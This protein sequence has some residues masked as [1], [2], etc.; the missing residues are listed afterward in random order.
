MKKLLTLKMIQL[1]VLSLFVLVLAVGCS[2]NEPAPGTDVGTSNNVEYGLTLSGVLAGGDYISFSSDDDISTFFKGKVSGNDYYYRGF[3]GGSVMIDEEMDMGMAVKSSAQS[4]NA[5]PVAPGGMATGEDGGLDYSDTNV[6]VEGIDEADIIKTDG[7]FIYVTSGNHFF[8]VKAYPGEEAQV[9][10]SYELSQ[11]P[12]GLFVSGDKV[13]IVDSSYGMKHFDIRASQY[14]TTSRVTVLDVSDRETPTQITNYSIEGDY[15]TARM[16][17]DDIYVVTTYGPQDWQVPL[18]IIMREETA[19][20]IAPSNVFRMPIMYKNPQL[21]S[22]HALSVSDPTQMDTISVAVEGHPTVYMSHEN[23]FLTSTKY[24]SEYDIR[25]EI[26]KE[27]VELPS[28]EQNLVSRINNVDD[29]ILTVNEKEGKVIQVY[30]EYIS[31]LDDSDE[32]YDK[33]TDATKKKLESLESSQITTVQRIALRTN[34]ASEDFSPQAATQLPGTLVNQFS[35]DEYDSIFRVAVTIQ[36]F[37]TQDRRNNEPSNAIYTFD[38]SLEVVDSLKGIAETERIF[39][40]RFMGDRLYM[41]TFRQTDPFFVYDLEDGKVTQL[42]ELKIP[43]FSRYLHPYDED[44]LIGLG[45]DAT[46]TGRQLGIKISL[47]DVSDVSNPTEVTSFVTEEKYAQTNAEYEHKAFLFDREKE[48]LVIPAR[49]YDWRNDGEGY[50][51]AFV[52]DISRV[53]IELRG[54]I[55]HSRGQNQYYGSGVLRSLYIEDDLYTMSEGLI[56]VNDLGD[57]HSVA[58]VSLTATGSGPIKVY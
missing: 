6:Q 38:Q 20:D 7:E 55:D 53:S 21:A 17:G 52:F 36:P 16:K 49:S 26:M 35:M 9:L 33:I 3:N 28:R 4:P 18:P 37:W 42:G 12:Q 41:V 40:T 57:L 8:I 34:S 1:I 23:I 10:S 54:L 27:L 15:V 56:R 19:L 45:H 58:N 30:N 32:W 5:M 13:F 50:N 31:L 29:E 24:L 39:S 46:E 44:T 43:G 47:F 22:V 2:S 25:N 51:G 14:G 48:L 11:N